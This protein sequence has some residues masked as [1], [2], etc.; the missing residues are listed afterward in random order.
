MQGLMVYFRHPNQS[1]SYLVFC[2]IIIS[3]GGSV[4]I[5]IE[6]LA[7]LAAA[8]HQHLA[9]TLALLNLVGAVGSSLDATISGAIWTNTF[10]RHSSAIFRC[11]SSRIWSI[12]TGIWSRSWATPLEAYATGIPERLRLCLD[13]DACYWN[14]HYGFRIDLNASH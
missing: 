13:W 2:Q 3:I 6:K 4:F 8:D 7:M 10:K 14:R 11:L 9:S 1:V 12:S 5:I